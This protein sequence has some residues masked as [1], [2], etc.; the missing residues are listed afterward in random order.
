MAGKTAA[1]P[2][3]DYIGCRKAAAVRNIVE[4]YIDFVGLRIDRAAVCISAPVA[5]Y[6]GC[7]AVGYNYFRP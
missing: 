1:A 6:I 4:R 7:P 5:G 3:A 2:A